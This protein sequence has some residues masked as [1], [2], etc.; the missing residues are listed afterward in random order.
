M[1]R[2]PR[3]TALQTLRLLPIEPLPPPPRVPSFEYPDADVSSPTGTS[4]TALIDLPTPV[5]RAGPWTAGA[6]EDVAQTTRW[7]S[8]SRYAAVSLDAPIYRLFE[9][10]TVI[11]HLPPAYLH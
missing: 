6:H 10:Q 2:S 3:P 8:P 4:L 9:A 11:V 5:N 7:L 1:I